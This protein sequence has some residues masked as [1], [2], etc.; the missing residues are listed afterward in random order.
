MRMLLAYALVVVVF[1]SV[2]VQAQAPAGGE[3]R[4]SSATAIGDARPVIA[5]DASGSF[6]V[7]WLERSAVPPLK[8]RWYDPLGVP[9]A[10]QVTVTGTSY[11]YGS[12]AGGSRF[13]SSVRSTNTA[14]SSRE[15]GAVG[16]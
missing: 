5:A 16:Q 2:A 15:T 3:F 8:A 7:T 12:H 13:G 9:R 1:A 10:G 11:H 6:V 4:V 14:I